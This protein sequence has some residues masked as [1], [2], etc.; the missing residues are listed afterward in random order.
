MQADVFPETSCE[1]RKISADVQLSIV[2]KGTLR[3]SRRASGEV[4]KT[5]YKS[6]GGTCTLYSQ[7]NLRRRLEEFKY[8]SSRRAPR[9]VKKKILHKSS[10]GCRYIVPKKPLESSKR[11][12]GEVQKSPS[13]AWWRHMYRQTSRRVFEYLYRVFCVFPL[14]LLWIPPEKSPAALKFGG[15][16]NSFE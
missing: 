15:V 2:P 7:M 5:L 1:L 12:S 13:K 16:E 14:K 9:E 3:S 6:S 8:T 10:K 11:A 4:Q